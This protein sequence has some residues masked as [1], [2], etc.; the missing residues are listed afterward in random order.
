M[1]KVVTIVG[2]RPELI[3]MSAVV[4]TISKYASH[5]LVHTGQNYDHNLNKVF[6]DDLGI[7]EPK[8]YLDVAS[9]S[10]KLM[11][12]IGNILVRVDDILEIERPDAVLIYGDTNSCLSV[13]AAKRRKIPIFHMEAGNRCFDQR[14]PEEVNRKIVDHLSD[15]NLTLTLR[16]REYLISEGLRPDHVLHVGSHMDEVINNNLRKIES[17]TILE[18]LSIKPHEYFVVSIHREEN[19]DDIN[20]LA[21]ILQAVDRVAIEFNKKCILTLHPRTRARLSSATSEIASTSMIVYADPFSFTDYV[22]MQQHC[23]CLLS[24]SG[25][26]SEESRIL[27]IPAI[28][29]RYTHERPEGVELGCFALGS[30][31]VPVLIQQIKLAVDTAPNKIEFDRLSLNLSNKISKIVLGYIDYLNLEVWKK[32]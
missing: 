21:S 26:V 11:E 16:A 4:K 18:K 14:V 19:V 29:L 20:I 15:I 12:T 32:P 25:T 24:D 28:T 17:S 22:C 6:F 9:G 10:D 23:F 8:Y 3:K 7:A 30:S 13:L 1:H 2:T 31:S 27:G 5:V